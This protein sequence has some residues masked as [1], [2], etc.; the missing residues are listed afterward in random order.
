MHAG[1]GKA[2]GHGR[3][4][5]GL[6]LALLASALLGLSIFMPKLHSATIQ[7][8]D[9]RLI[10]AWE[11][12]MLIGCAALVVLGAGF[13]LRWRRWGW[14]DCGAGAAA[15]GAVIYASSGSRLTVQAAGIG[16]EAPVLGVPGI[17]LLTAGLAALV[18]IGAGLMIVLPKARRPRD[19]DPARC[20]PL[21]P[22]VT[23]P[24]GP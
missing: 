21:A 2:E 15:L 12:V 16:G 4:W 23:D 7:L 10:D 17:G 19:S 6:A 5:G 24:R 13:G 11:G 8:H 18:A 20:R 1:G 9:N 22:R 14:F 3:R